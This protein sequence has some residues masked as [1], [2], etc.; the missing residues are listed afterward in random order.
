MQNVL[1]TGGAGFI[2]ANF[3]VHALNNGSAEV[4]VFDNQSASTFDSISS[5]DVECVDGDVR[6][7]PAL[8]RAM[9]HL[10]E[11]KKTRLMLTL[12][13][14]AVAEEGFDWNGCVAEHQDHYAQELR[15]AGVV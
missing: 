6:D 12:R 2:G 4:R 5:L 8:A 13:A 10:V 14:R 11:E 3:V 15:K 1:I 9:T 7:R